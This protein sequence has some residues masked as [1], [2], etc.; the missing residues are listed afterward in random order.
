[1]GRHGARRSWPAAR[2]VAEYYAKSGLPREKFRV[3]PSGVEIPTAPVATRRQLL[4]EL[5]LPDDARLVGL[6]GRLLPHKR[7]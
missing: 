2:A 4:D 3:I 5:G 6:V 1:M 7:W